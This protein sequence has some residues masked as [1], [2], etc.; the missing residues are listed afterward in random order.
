MVMLVAT[1][2]RKGT[3]TLTGRIRARCEDAHGRVVE[4]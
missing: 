4:S 3:P 1:C 2:T